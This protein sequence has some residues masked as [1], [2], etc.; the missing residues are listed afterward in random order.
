MMMMMM[1]M[2]MMM[3]TTIRNAICVPLGELLP[4]KLRVL[5]EFRRW[6]GCVSHYYELIIDSIILRQ[7]VCVL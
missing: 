1:M 6:C 7:N 3:T 5:L 2:T 4:G